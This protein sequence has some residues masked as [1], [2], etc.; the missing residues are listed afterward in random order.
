MSLGRR[1]EGLQIFV[2]QGR[3]PR[4]WLLAL[5]LVACVGSLTACG[6]DDA[7]ALAGTDLQEIPSPGFA[8]VDQ[9]GQ[10]VSLADLRGQAVAL[11]FIY[12]SCPDVCPLIATKMRDA[13]ERLSSDDRSRVAL[14]AITVDPE[15]DT[16]EA[17][18]AFT[19][20]HDLADTPQWYALTGERAALASV[21]KS[22]G[23]EPG[24]FLHE[25]NH[26]EGHATVPA[27]HQA[28]ASPEMLAHTDA[29]YF[30]DPEGRERALLRGDAAP[31]AIAQNLQ[32]L[33]N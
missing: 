2:E 33:I 1:L 8:L 28:A 16:A 11:T 25:A 18:R 17:L 9:R 23:I 20:Q 26:A 10:P 6:G 21:W 30:I 5:L 22:Y 7:P 13:Y 32:V 29:I 24:D 14:V 4:N 31:E 3:D 12:T 27:E 15:R 19:A